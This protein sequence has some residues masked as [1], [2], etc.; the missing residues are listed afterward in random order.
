MLIAVGPKMV[1]MVT[2]LMLFNKTFFPFYFSGI[3]LWLVTHRLSDVLHA[4]FILYPKFTVF[5]K[6]LTEILDVIFGLEVDSWCRLLLPKKVS[7]LKL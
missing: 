4:S 2:I 7:K 5:S 3:C 1:A 6:K